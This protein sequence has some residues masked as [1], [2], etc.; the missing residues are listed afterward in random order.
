MKQPKYKMGDLV[1]VFCV[2]SYRDL[3]VCN[4][5]DIIAAC[6]DESLAQQIITAKGINRNWYTISSR[7]MVITTTEPLS[8]FFIDSFKPY[9]LNV[10][11]P[12]RKEDLK[13]QALNK[14]TPEE[15]SALGIK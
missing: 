1:N 15:K 7:K 2:E 14:L 13:A 6:T 10:D 12:Q 8:G 9:E 4:N 5:T 11:H 3:P